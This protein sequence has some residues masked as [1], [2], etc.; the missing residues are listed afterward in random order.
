MSTPWT[1]ARK[2]LT[3]RHP[4][5]R[6]IRL[7]EYAT[8]AT[9]W[10]SKSCFTK[11]KRLEPPRGRA[12]KRSQRRNYVSS[13]SFAHASHCRHAASNCARPRRALPPGRRCAC[14]RVCRRCGAATRTSDVSGPPG[15]IG[16]VDESGRSLSI[17][18]PEAGRT[19]LESH[20]IPHPAPA[21]RQYFA[22][23]YRQE[24]QT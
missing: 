17:P 21:R 19:E 13:R 15:A 6:P 10:V 2:F 5:G 9:R 23:V 8:L 11:W 16:G 1:P 3:H 20:I 22:S 24:G 18:E 14:Q 7:C 4:P 12:A